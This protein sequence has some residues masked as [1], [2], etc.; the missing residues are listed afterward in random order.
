MSMELKDGKFNYTWDNDCIFKETCIKRKKGNCNETCNIRPE[1]EYLISSSNIPEK[2]QKPVVLN[3]EEEDLTAFQTLAQIKEDVLNFVKD[4][5]V[6][7][8][9]SHNIGN[10][11]S[12]WSCKIL[13]TYLAL[14]SNGNCFKDRAWFEYVPT[15]LLLSKEFKS[16]DRNIHIQN[17]MDREL[18]VIDDIGAVNNSN[19]DIS[20]LSSIIDNR[21]SKNLATIY[22]S[23]LSP[24]ELERNIGVR[25]A[26]R[27]CSDIVIQLK[28]G[29][30]RKSTS[31]YSKK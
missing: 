27:V 25:L 12:S 30:R 17:C 28:G 26:D 23:N 19:Y 14:I 6:L 9:W 10:S 3:A 24:N 8:L 21:Y 1:F 31:K 7:Y 16:E 22:T 4:G 20:V 18:I 5:R 29:G 13:N 11:K 15:F 2:F